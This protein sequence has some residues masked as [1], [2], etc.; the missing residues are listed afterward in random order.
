MENIKVLVI[1]HK[2][3]RMPAQK[4]Y[5]PIHV[6][7][8][9]KD[10]LGYTGDDTGE[11]ISK[12]NPNYCELTGLYWYLKNKIDDDVEYV[13]V[14]HYRRYFLPYNNEFAK[15]SIVRISFDKWEEI[16]K[17]NPNFL[18]EAAKDVDVILPVKRVYPMSIRAQ[19]STMHYREH[20]DET[21]SIIK[22]FY[23]RYEKAAEEY[24]KGNKSHLYNMFVIKKEYYKEMMEWI[25]DVLF[26][27]E[28]RIE[29][30]N[31]VQQARVFGFLSERLV[32][33]FILQNNLKVK[34][35]PVAFISD[36]E[37]VKKDKYALNK[38][39]SNTAFNVGNKLWDYMFYEKNIRIKKSKSK[40]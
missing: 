26:K 23:P 28:E 30:P 32:N 31:D 2:K 11:N 12:K 39:V 10:D 17:Q 5:M 21:V 22:E 8:A 25:F 34:E 27:L 6:G 40:K 38:A 4:I 1:T 14:N 29:I 19:Y 7:K 18:Y 20:L 35:L 3:T 9:G 36:E 24:L 13:G 37:I 16:N 33:I 15:S